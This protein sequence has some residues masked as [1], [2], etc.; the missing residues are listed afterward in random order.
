MS[1]NLLTKLQSL[2]K[3]RSSV[4][5]NQQSLFAV[6]SGDGK[7]DVGVLMNHVRLLRNVPWVDLSIGWMVSKVVSSAVVVSTR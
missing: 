4:I 2:T 3:V 1:L 7:I 5:Y 6:G